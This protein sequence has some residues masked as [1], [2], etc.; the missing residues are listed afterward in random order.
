MVGWGK[1][2]ARQLRRTVRWAACADTQLAWLA[3][4]LSQSDRLEVRRRWQSRRGMPLVHASSR[5]FRL[6]Y[7]SG[8]PNTPGHI[9]RVARSAAAAQAAGAQ[10]IWIQVKDI[11]ARLA[12]IEVADALAIWRASWNVHT[13]AAIEAARRGGT[14][15]VFDID[16]LLMDPNLARL[17]I[18]DGIRSQGFSEKMVRDFCSS[19]RTTMIAADLCIATTDELASHMQRA[20]KPAFVLPNGYDYASLAN[21][22][23]AV[24]HR[25]AKG[26]GD[27]LVRIGYAGGTL[28]HQRDFK[29]CV[30]AVAEVLRAR[31]DCRLVAFRWADGES[32][33]LDIDEFPALNGLEDRIEW[34]HY[35][36]L[37]NCRTSWRDLI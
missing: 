35:V 28:T 4:L 13:A 1:A 12:E 18:I 14:T 29:L 32:A 25:R 7:I 9:Y 33:I 26:Q 20:G 23:L 21:S 10:T 22:R 30:A 5:R 11:P 19:M 8:E 16:D 36:A 27:G 17:D 31:S 37:S 2:T 3:K 6:V 34:R 15:I 24:R